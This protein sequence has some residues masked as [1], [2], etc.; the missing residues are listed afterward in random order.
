MKIRT[1]IIFIWSF[2]AIWFGCSKN[3]VKPEY[4][5]EIIVFGNLWGNQPLNQEHA[6]SIKYTQP[7]TDIYNDFQTAIR[8]ASVT[9]TDS[10]TGSS[11]TLQDNDKAPGYYFNDELI[12]QP[13]VTYLLRVETD[14]KV[15]TG[16]TT[17]PP[18]ITLTSD[19]K[20]DTVNTEHQKNLGYNKPI[21]VDCDC[22][23]D[24]MIVVDMFCDESLEDAKFINPFFGFDKPETPEDYDGGRNAEPRHIKAFVAFQDLVAPNFESRHTIYWYASMIVFYG[25]NTMQVMAVDDNYNNYTFAEHPV[26]T[27]GIQGGLGLF[28]SMCGETYQLNLVEE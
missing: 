8:N 12:I 24:L 23:N 11:W 22:P 13:L 15:V 2:S 4:Q 5:Q 28:A 21:Y 7:I 18:M 6:I 9:I 10:L 25:Q 26:Y 1:I 27:G 16:S 19:L 20:L 14:N 17:V 3:P